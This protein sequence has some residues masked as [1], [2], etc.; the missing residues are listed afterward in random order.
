MGTTTYTNCLRIKRTDGT[1]VCLTELDKDLTINDTALGLSDGSHTYLSAAGYTPTDLQS[2][3]DNSV[4]NADVEGVLSSIGVDRDDIIAG[5]Y[6]FARLHIFMW[7]Y[8]TNSLVKKLG[9]GHWGEVTIKDGSYVA[10]YR[11]LSQQL[12]QNIGRTF[13]PECDEQL[14]GTRCGVNLSSYTDTFTVGVLENQSSFDISTTTTND[15]FAY[16]KV[17]W[18]SGNNSGLSMEV[19]QN[20]TTKFDLQ[21]PMPFPI[22]VGDT[23]TVYQ[24][25]DKRLSTCKTKFSNHINFQ[26]FPFI[27]GQD[28]ILRFG[29]Q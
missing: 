15:I 27:P 9:T 24:G 8:E 23:F 2:T 11:S 14:G 7:N 29:G 5:L 6:D 26:G 10:E 3:S 25:C 13:N 28:A 21:L 18:T 22:Q 17:T 4:N 12:Q 19:K 16:G 20:D 1:I